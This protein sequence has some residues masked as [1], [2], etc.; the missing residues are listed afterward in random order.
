MKELGKT[1]SRAVLLHQKIYEQHPDVGAILL[2]IR[3]TPWL[4]P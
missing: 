1:P 4:L 3:S 2:P